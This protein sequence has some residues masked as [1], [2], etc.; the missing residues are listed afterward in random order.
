M[1]CTAKFCGG[2]SRIVG[3]KTYHTQ[4][5]VQNSLGRAFT[6]EISSICFSPRTVGARVKLS[7]DQ[8]SLFDKPEEKDW[9]GMRPYSAS[10]KN[11]GGT[12]KAMP[13]EKE[14]SPEAQSR[15][16][17]QSKQSNGGKREPAKSKQDSGSLARSLEPAYTKPVAKSRGRSAH[18]TLGCA[19]GFESRETNFDVLRLCDMEAS[20][21]ATDADFVPVTGGRAR[22]FGDGVCCV[23]FD[24]PLRVSTIYSGLY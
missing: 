5:T 1:H 15:S 24:P 11:S 12:S 22:C 17:A 20:L 9:N 10:A 14:H 21:T 16:P 23:Y 18:I 19:Q 6:L 8:L 2:S 4:Q 3:A 7:E 13:K